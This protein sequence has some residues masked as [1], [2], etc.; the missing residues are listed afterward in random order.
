MKHFIF[1]FLLAV[2]M[3]LVSM[4]DTLTA[5][6]LNH[7]IWYDAF[8]SS[9]EKAEYIDRKKIDLEMEKILDPGKSEI[10]SDREFLRELPDDYADMLCKKCLPSSRM[11]VYYRRK[12]RKQD[13]EIR[14]LEYYESMILNR[15]S[16]QFM[17]Q[18]IKDLEVRLKNFLFT[19]CRA[20]HGKIRYSEI[21]EI[22]GPRGGSQ[23]GLASLDFG[24][25]LSL[26]KKLAAVKGIDLDID[27]LSKKTTEIRILKRDM[28]LLD[29]IQLELAT[30]R[31]EF[32]GVPAEIKNRLYD[33]LEC[34]CLDQKKGSAPQ[35]SEASSLLKGT[36]PVERPGLPARPIDDAFTSPKKV[37]PVPIPEINIPPI[38]GLYD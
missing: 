9:I 4:D 29:R 24:T 1:V 14:T 26:A 36:Q 28:M 11:V 7:A 20:L 35:T 38:P 25:L 17:L 27:T 8:A 13:A 21:S 22:A 12:I 10:A 5:E 15:Y 2:L 3:N 16:K 34:G 19:L 23:K 18:K 30:A 37:E 32:Q 33:I 6:S 31:G